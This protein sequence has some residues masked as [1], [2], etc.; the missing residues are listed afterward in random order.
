MGHVNSIQL[1][2]S[3]QNALEGIAARASESAGVVRRVHV[4]LWTAQGVPASEIAARLGLSC[5]AVSRIRR[6]F[7]ESGVDGL[8]DRPKT[9]RK[10]HALPEQTIEQIVQLALSP[11][12]AGRTRWTTRLLAKEVGITSGTVSDVLRRHSLKPHRVRTYKVEIPSSRRKCAISWAC[13]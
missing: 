12:P 5:E 10:D 13:T 2:R 1:S 4:V 8:F 11:P 7:L 6:R 3:Q 9:G